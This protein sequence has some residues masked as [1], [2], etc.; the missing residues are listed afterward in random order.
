MTSA[1]NSSLVAVNES[2][3]NEADPYY[4][5]KNY[6]RVVYFYCL[7][8]ILPVGIIC[9]IFCVAIMSSSRK[10]RKSTT[11]H[12][13]LA[14]A[15]ADTVFLIGEMLRWSSWSAYGRPITGLRLT[16]DYDVIC[17]LTHYLRY[18]GKLMSAW[19]IVVITAERFIIIAFPLK[20]SSI[21]T[22]PKARAVIILV[23]ILSFTLGA[24]PLWT[25]KQGLHKKQATCMYTNPKEYSMWSNVVLR[26]GQLL[27]PSFIVFM[28]TG[29]IIFYLLKAGNRRRNLQHYWQAAGGATQRQTSLC[30]ESQ[31]TMMLLFVAVAFLLLRLPYTLTYYLDY[32][33]KSLWPDMSHYQSY[34]LYVTLKVSDIVATTN[35]AVNFFVY[36][37][38]G[39]IFRQQV[40]ICLQCRNIRRRHG[41]PRSRSF[42]L[43]S[44][45]SA[46]RRSS[47]ATKL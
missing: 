32:Y 29:L 5:A 34:Q 33:K 11:A 15:C 45:L 37:F 23:V 22:L 38:S 27:I 28:L 44:F 10:L 1:E 7:A 19:M 16:H 21:S 25:I 39:G 6:V 31:L 2:I 8:V 40:K 9:N 26:F 14:L 47:T 43:S 18:S 4:G 30:V 41:R 3:K 24:F 42:T 35:Y 17:R 13:L 20:V 12:Y 46:S 36:C